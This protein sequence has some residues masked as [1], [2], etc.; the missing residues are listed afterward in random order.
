MRQYTKGKNSLYA[1]EKY[2]DDRE[3]SGYGGQSES[4]FWEAA[5]TTKKIV[6]RLECVD[7]KYR[8]KR[9]LAIKRCQT[10]SPFFFLSLFIYFEREGGH[11]HTSRGGAERERESKQALCSTH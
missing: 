3:R 7:P 1:Q 11:M 4:I 2:H 9:M 6:L 8:S 10:S 5:K